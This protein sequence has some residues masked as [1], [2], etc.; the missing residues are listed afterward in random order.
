MDFVKKNWV[1]LA[2]G[3]VA[4]ASIG[5]AAWAYL[6]GDEIY[7]HVEEMDKLRNSVNSEANNAQNAATIEAKKAEQAE[8]LAAQEKTLKAAL[9]AQM[10]NSFE[11]RDRQTLVPDVLP[12]SKSSAAQIAFKDA[13]RKAFAE[14]A[15]RLN[16]RDKATSDEIT[17]EQAYDDAKSQQANTDEDRGPWM[18]A[19]PKSDESPA[20][21]AGAKERTM[22]EILRAYPKARAAEKV[23]RKIYMY[24]DERAFEPESNMLISDTP[25]TINIWHAQMT[26]WIQQDFAY[27]IAR[28]NDKR[29][30]ELKAKNRAYDAWVAHMPVKRLRLLAG[31]S[32]LGRGG[33]MN[34][35]K[36]ELPSFTGVVN[37]GQKFI[38]PLQIKVV[39]EEASILEL[40]DSICRV[41]YYT[42]TRVE[43]RNVDPMPLQD[44]Y[45][46]GDDP[47]VEATIDFEGTFFRK[48]FDAYIPKE[49]GAGL[50]RPEAL[51]ETENR[52]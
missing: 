5:T 14:L 2:L 1:Y 28:L 25:K 29:A 49:L 4:V 22:Q 3:V 9:G 17:R 19:P 20:V 10:Y 8:L 18:P 35:A 46:Y 15:T 24:L 33:G 11:G 39:V 32:W 42:P 37:D 44:E 51:E 31:H 50:A 40:I 47:V 6:A 27:A 16:A 30:E 12:A 21:K 7:Q 38:V 26:L 52:R 13:Y 36:F 45:I 48:V 34:M 41:G 23:A 43:Y